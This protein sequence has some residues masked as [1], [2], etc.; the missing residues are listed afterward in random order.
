MRS[1]LYYFCLTTDTEI[2][3]PSDHEL[4]SLKQRAQINISSFKLFCLMCGF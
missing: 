1:Q 2:M 4:K 3:E